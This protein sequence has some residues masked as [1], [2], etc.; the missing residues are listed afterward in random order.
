MRGRP[1]TF[2]G[3]TLVQLETEHRGARSVTGS[4]QTSLLI[5]V[6][7]RSGNIHVKE[8][9][10]PRLVLSEATQGKTCR[11]DFENIYDKHY[12]VHVFVSF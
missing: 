2:V 5:D 9:V 7:Q 11:P 3:F 10:T 12:E 4:L 6:R 8:D 1:P